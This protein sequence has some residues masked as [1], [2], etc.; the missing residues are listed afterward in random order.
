MSHW[1]LADAETAHDLAILL[2]RAARLDPGAACRI[3]GT[4]TVAAVYVCVLSGS[5]GPT[6]LGLRTLALAEPSDVDAVVPISAVTD[7]LARAE[8]GNR[9]PVPPQQLH[10]SWAGVLPPRTGWLPADPVAV[11]DLRRAASD[12]IAEIALG[13]GEGSG[14]AAVATLRA[15]VWGRPLP[16]RA[17]VPTGAGFAAHTLGFLIG[18]TLSVHTVGPWTRLSSPAGFVLCRPALLG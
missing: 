13:A 11:D 16:G 10:V 7:R 17:D 2:A 12:G 15:K 5:G 4:G 1:E 9:L 6:V 14:S 8:N 3:V 18:A